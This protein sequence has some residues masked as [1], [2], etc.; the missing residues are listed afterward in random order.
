MPSGE[1]FSLEKVSKDYGSLHALSEVTFSV[2]QGEAVGYLGPNGAGKTTTLKLLSGLTR[3]TSGTLR[4]D[5]VEPTKDRRR[6]LSS[7]GVLVETPGVLPYVRGRDLLEHIAEVKGVPLN[8]RGAAVLHATK[9]LDVAEPSERLLG[10]LSTGLLRRV[11]LAGALIGD[12]KVLVLDEPTMGLDPAA[13]N[14]LRNILRGLKKEGRTIFLSTHLLEDVEEVCE[15]VL[16]LRAGRLMGEAP[17]SPDGQAPSSVGPRTLLVRT[18]DT[19]ARERVG[20]AAGPEVGIEESEPGTE[21]L[22]T[23]RGDERRQSEL[24]RALIAGGVPVSRAQPV[25]SDLSSLYMQKV[26]REEAT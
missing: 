6:A 3:P 5:G 18:S 9:T 17:V 11:L 1:A 22:L 19:T 26:G 12:P 15:R 2:R 7:V 16:F 21:F 20:R 24:L 23:F 14:D 13:R 10:S 25:G 4:L 8:E